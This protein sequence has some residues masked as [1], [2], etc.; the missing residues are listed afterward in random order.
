MSD[1][2]SQ[3]PRMSTPRDRPLS[4][5]FSNQDAEKEWSSPVV[6]QAGV[7][8]FIRPANPPDH[9][10]LKLFFERVSREDLYFRFLSGLRHVDEDRLNQMLDDT[11][12]RA[13]DFLAVA[14]ESGEVLASALLCADEDFQTAEFAIVTREDMKGRGISWALLNHAERYARA[15]GIKKITSIESAS[16]SGALSL[17]REM[18]FAVHSYPGDSTLLLAEKTF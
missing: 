6:T 12:D 2:K 17:E 7:K 18:G 11:D 9:D 14:L 4:V 3:S 16:Q 5:R 15:M 1:L 10:A 8:L 13:I